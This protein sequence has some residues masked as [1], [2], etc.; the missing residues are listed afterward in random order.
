MSIVE[1]WSLCGGITW[2]LFFHLQHFIVKTSYFYISKS[3]CINKIETN[4]KQRDATRGTD[5][6][7]DLLQQLMRFCT[8][9]WS[10][11]G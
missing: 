9:R 7:C 6:I 8:H 4:Q 5:Q 3:K 2:H 1:R 11:A 10:D